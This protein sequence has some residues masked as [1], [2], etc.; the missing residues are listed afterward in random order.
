M[1]SP[2]THNH[3]EHL[4][5]HPSRLFSVYMHAFYDFLK[6]VSELQSLEL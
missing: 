4:E 2:P 1:R 3:E 6:K 5:I